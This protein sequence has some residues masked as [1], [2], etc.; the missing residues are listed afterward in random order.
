[1]RNFAA[2]ARFELS[3]RLR[4]IS[5]WVYFVVFAAIAMLWVGAAGGIIP[6]AIVSFGSSKV[7]INSP[8]AVSQ[9]VSYLGMVAMTVVA[10]LMGRAVQQDFEYRTDHFFFS[11]PIR[12][13]QYLG[14][15]FAG[16]LVVLLAI[17]SSI[18]IGGF[19]GLLLPGIHPDP[20]GPG[21]APPPFIPDRTVVGATAQ[22]DS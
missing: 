1:M 21:R 20:V 22:R 16:A 2:I 14:G 10:A 19:F 9:T 8:Y 13:W 7:W 18:A 4:R 12:K 15:R 11:S 3:T 5:T 6:N 17:L